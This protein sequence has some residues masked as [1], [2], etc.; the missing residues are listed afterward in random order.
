[1]I[2]YERTSG[3]DDRFVKL[4]AALDADLAVR[5]GDDHDFYHQFNGLD[6]IHHAIIASRNGMPV[7]CGAFKA[8]DQQTVEIKRMYTLPE[9][10]GQGI[11]G[12]LLKELEKWAGELQHRRCVLETGLQQPEA[13]RLYEHSGYVRTENYGQYKGIENSQCFEKVL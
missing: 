2:V 4:V 3:N 6:D 13:I 5:D 11:A 12:Q 8:F 1:M 9:H 7:S 10:R